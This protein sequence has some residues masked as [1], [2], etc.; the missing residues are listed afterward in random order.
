MPVA[1]RLAALAQGSWHGTQYPAYGI[2]QRTAGG[3]DDIGH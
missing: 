2:T 1:P 3:S